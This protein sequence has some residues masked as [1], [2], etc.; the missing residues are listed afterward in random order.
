MAR[1]LFTMWD[2]G[3]SLPPEL[4]VVRQL[5]EAGHTVAAIGDPV[6]EPEVRAVGVTDFRP[7]VDAPHHVTRRAEDDY[8]RDWEFRNPTRLLA[9]I[10]DTLMVR[11][12]PLFAAET[13]AAIDDVQPDV[14]ASSF[15]LFGALLAGETRGLPCAVLVP[16]VVALPA[17]GMPPMGTGFH[18]AKGILG[19]ARD[20]AING[21]ID[22]SFNKGLPEL[23]RVRSSLGL[24][25][26][27]RLLAQYDR[28]ARVLALTAA[29]FDFPA[30]LPPNVRYV[31][32][33][34]DDPEWVEPWTPPIHDNRPL[35]LIAMSTTFMD[36][37]DQL[38]RTVT[39]LGALAV[40]GLVTTGPAVDPDQIDAP[41][42]VTVVRSA[43]H[44]EVLAHTDVLV[45]HGGHGTVMKGLVAGVPI[46]CMPTGRDQPDNAARLTSRGAGIKVSK[47]ASPA[48]IAAAVQR[49]LDE[50][51][52]K[53]AA[54][55]LGRQVRVEA[56]SGTAVA[57]LEALASRQ[58]A[59]AANG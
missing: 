27:D 10:L 28:A 44:R 41:D 1:Y 34:L 57:E 11:P 22:R 45:T 3:G 38:Q 25:P 50:P 7:W 39:A 52:F 21:L 30:S 4:T 26:L 24:A 16:N 18:P 46:V 55:T 36:H 43:P 12:A 42:N 32:P 6:I 33:Q 48:K 23:N 9:N 40:R 58:C 15:P 19:R 2:G 54:E 14:V 53:T 8:V 49:V 59:S 13:M 51:A 35:V 5:V 31:G 17:D 20:R 47:K 37:V 29:A 56:G